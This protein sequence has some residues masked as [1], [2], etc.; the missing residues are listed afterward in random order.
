M[1]NKSEYGPSVSNTDNSKF[2]N[3]LTNIDL[4]VTIP[5]LESNPGLPVITEQESNATL[6]LANAIQPNKVI[7]GTV[8]PNGE[9]W[10]K[11]DLTTEGTITAQ[12]DM[13]NRSAD[14]KLYGPNKS[15]IVG[16]EILKSGMIH[17][18]TSDLGEYY[19]LVTD[20]N[21]N[22]SPYELIVDIV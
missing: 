6:Q 3:D 10:F 18:T 12:L 7:K 19:I 15:E 13:G 22:N 16:K 14:L 5:V 4:S 9:D 1:N 2:F 20:G 17:H 8:F 11:F 21:I